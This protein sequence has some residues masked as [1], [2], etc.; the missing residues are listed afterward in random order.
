MATEATSVTTSDHVAAAWDLLA[1]SDRH[2]A[3]RNH[4]QASETLWKATVHAI[5][6]IAA[7]RGWPCDGGRRSL[8]TVVEQ[9][10]EEESDELIS[11]TYIYAENFRDNAQT[12]FMELRALAYDG[13]KARGYIRCLLAMVC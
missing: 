9:L 3:A 12:D 6:A 7:H 13:A 11:L 1:E 4:L 8:R 5:M 10:S 2:F